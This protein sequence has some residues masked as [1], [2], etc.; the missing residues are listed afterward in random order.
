MG[1]IQDTCIILLAPI[2]GHV[3]SRFCILSTARLPAMI[4]SELLQTFLGAWGAVYP[5]YSLSHMYHSTVVR[6]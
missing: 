2:E 4:N 6:F 3:C 5:S 1:F